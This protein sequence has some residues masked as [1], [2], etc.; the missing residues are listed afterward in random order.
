MQNSYREETIIWADVAKCICVFLV[1]IL[2]MEDH[3]AVSGWTDDGVI[4]QAW[5]WINMFLRPIRLPML[6]LVSGM[7]SAK[8]ILHDDKDTVRKYLIKPIYLYGLWSAIFVTLIPLY[9]SSA[10]IDLGPIE[11]MRLVLLMVSPAWYLL[12]L[13]GFYC[14]A[15]VTR[16]CDLRWLLLVCALISLCGSFIEPTLSTQTHKLAR[17][18]VF[19][20]AGVRL[21]DALLAYT[22]AATPRLLVVSGLFFLGAGTMSVAVGRY[23]LPVD[24]VAAAFSLQL[25][26]LIATRCQALHPPARWLGQRTLYIYLLHFPLEVLLSDAV[27]HNAGPR[28]LGNAM[29]GM[30]YPL[31]AAVVVV[32]AALVLGETMRRCGF[33]WMFD[34]PRWQ[35]FER[36]PATARP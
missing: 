8:S 1:V 12:A 35:G 15:T 30:L 24:L 19:F 31:A 16:R 36:K 2:H 21:R 14:I 32:P 7:L 34:L 6:F 20:I 10:N 28:L 4:T 25:A 3:I 17:C 26:G 22:A 18:L 33:A 23:L 11:R 5:H 9:P 27:R 13:A 29:A